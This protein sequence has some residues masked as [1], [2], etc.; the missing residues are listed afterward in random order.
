MHNDKKIKEIKD[1]LRNFQIKPITIIKGTSG[2]GK[3]H[4]AKSILAEFKYKI[5]EVDSAF[6][7]I[8][9]LNEVHPLMYSM[10][11]Q[12]SKID[13]QRVIILKEISGISNLNSLRQLQQQYTY[14]K[15]NKPLVIIVNTTVLKDYELTKI[16]SQEFIKIY[17]NIVLLKSP[18]NNKIEKYL[19]TCFPRVNSNV[20]HQ[21]AELSN[22]D[23]R[24][25]YNQAFIYSINYRDENQSKDSQLTFFNTVGRVLYN[26]RLDYYNTPKQ[27]TYEEMISKPEPKYYFD[28]FQ[29]LETIQVTQQT[30]RGFLFINSLK[31][32][33]DLNEMKQFYEIQSE[34]DVIE[35]GLCRFDRYQGDIFNNQYLVSM[36]VTL[37]Y[38]Q[39]NKHVKP[40]KSM[41]LTLNGPQDYQF[42]QERLLKQNEMK[43]LKPFK[44]Y[45]KELVLSILYGK[46][47]QLLN[48]KN[49][50]ISQIS[51]EDDQYDQHWF[52][53]DQQEQQQT[54]NKKLSSKNIRVKRNQAELIS[55]NRNQRL[56]E[57][58]NELLN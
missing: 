13:D 45:Q 34:A 37:G 57:V 15:C 26:K 46:R 49:N 38:M 32:L 29:L 19:H 1:G 17:C 22:G 48:S 53:E 56:I 39:T 43:Q 8:W 51:I 50:F 42:R 58:C 47:V 44:S 31:F 33:H 5:L 36:F 12:L 11:D 2:I 55:R 40:A 7:D 4:L 3:L 30:Y 28:P 41:M 54:S 35:K 16:L 23:I 24:N 25:A 21:I 20:L 14:T 9:M 10:Q 6:R 18:T 52:E 27:L